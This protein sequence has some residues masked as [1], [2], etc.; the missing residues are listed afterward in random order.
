MI[1]L[2]NDA[3]KAWLITWANK[4]ADVPESDGLACGG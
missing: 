3:L 4:R 1:T 2:N